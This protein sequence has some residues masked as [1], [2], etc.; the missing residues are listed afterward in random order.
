[1]ASVSQYQRARRSRIVRARN[2]TVASSQPCTGGRRISRSSADAAAPATSPKRRAPAS[3]CSIR[4]NTTI[5]A[6]RPAI[7]AITRPLLGLPCSDTNANARTGSP[8]LAKLFQ[9]PDNSSD[10]VARDCENPHE[11]Y[12][13]KFIPMPMAPP[14]GSV[15]DTAVEDSVTTM[16]CG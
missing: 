10:T 7:P 16:A 6:I 9:M 4:A 5:A 12:I 15:L 8:S 11:V 13:E 1:M 2:L 14:P 3:L